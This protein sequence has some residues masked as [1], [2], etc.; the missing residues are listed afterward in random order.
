M[1]NYDEKACMCVG[2]FMRDFA[3][4]ESI[5]Y[6]ILSTIF[7]LSSWSFLILQRGISFDS[8][9]QI[10]AVALEEQGIEFKDI[11]KKIKRH[12]LL[13]NVIAHSKFSG[14]SDG[15]EFDCVDRKGRLALPVEIRPRDPQDIFYD[16]LITYDELQEYHSEA[17]EILFRLFDIE[18]ACEPMKDGFSRKIVQKIDECFQGYTGNIIK[19]PGTTKMDDN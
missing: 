16:T 11:F 18:G 10:V 6:S 17:K 4:N 3:T 13:R 2:R 12:Q 7:D 1:D 15:V 19:F 9:L 5:L 14:E 8:K